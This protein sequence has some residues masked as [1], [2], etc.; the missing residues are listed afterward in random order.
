MRILRRKLYLETPIRVADGA[1][2][3]LLSWERLGAVWAEVLPR[4]GSQ[5]ENIAR[6]GLQIT[7]R[8]APQG[9]PMR[10]TPSQRF[11]DGTRIY[12]IDAV[13]EADG[14]GRY[15]ICFATEETGA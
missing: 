15:L 13:T 10:P 4:G 12:R 1:G 14:L 5:S 11:V 7:L 9:A 3:F 8:A 6:L 2:G